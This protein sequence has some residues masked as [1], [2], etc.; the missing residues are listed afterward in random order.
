MWYLIYI[1]IFI[2]SALASTLLTKLMIVVSHWFG[3]YDLPEG[4]KNHDRPIPYLGGVAIYVSFLGIVGIHMWLLHFLNGDFP[5]VAWIGDHLR[6]SIALGE[7]PAV[8]RALGIVLGGTLIF[9]VGLADDIYTLRARYKLAAQVIAAVIVVAFGVRLELFL[10][11]QIFSWIAT[12]FW[13]VLI[14]NAFN[15]IDN[16]DGLC[17][18]V[19]LIAALIFFFV[20]FPLHQTLTAA[21]L[22]VLA[23]TLFGFLIFN[24][25]P[26]KVFMGDAGAMFIGFTVASLTVVGTFYMADHM[27]PWGLFTPLLI[28]S[29]PI[30]DT[31]GVIYLRWKAD[32]PIHIGDNRHFSHRL[33]HLGMNRRDAVVFIYLVS[34]CV[35]LGATLLR[36]LG[37]MGAVTLFIQALGL[38]AIIIV[39]MMADRRKRISEQWNIQNEPEEKK[40]NEAEICSTGVKTGSSS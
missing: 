15:F 19:A 27:S 8:L 29:V 11:F 23:G 37:F 36:Y 13:I 5:L 24:F 7:K 3:F 31:L 38:F 4:R 6:Y 14:V 35:G 10:P 17:A 33:V 30:F 39:L 2:A 34:F 21:I 28:L 12:I 18:G 32:R 25:Y 40:E 9:L 20:V 26:A 16:M 1:Y 22:L